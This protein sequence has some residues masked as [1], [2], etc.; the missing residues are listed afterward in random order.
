[1]AGVFVCF[2][3]S[4]LIRFRLNHQTN[5][6]II[7]LVHD[8]EKTVVCLYNSSSNEL[9]MQLV[10]TNSIY[11]NYIIFKRPQIYDDVKA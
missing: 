3:V 6:S 5:A 4:S 2:V 9:C 11:I 8:Q 10:D 7:S 1:M